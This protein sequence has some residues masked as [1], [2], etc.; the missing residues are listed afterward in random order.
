[1]LSREG[2]AFTNILKLMKEQGYNK[3]IVVK[4]GII[5]NVSPLKINLGD[6]SVVSSDIIKASAF[7]NSGY[8][9]NDKVIVII[10][11]NEI[12]VLDKVVA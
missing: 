10:D 11:G 1:M 8:K 7:N 4:L 12:F 9:T 5:T 6:F 2:G 3:D